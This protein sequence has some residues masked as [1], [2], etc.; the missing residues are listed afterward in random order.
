MWLDGDL[1]ELHDAPAATPAFSRGSLEL[2]Q[3]T[4][5]TVSAALTSSAATAD[6]VGDLSE[7][8][9]VAL[10]A[11]ERAL[12]ALQ[13]AEGELGKLD[14]AAGDGDH[15]A[16]MVRGMGAAVEAARGGGGSAGQVLAKAGMAFSGAA[17]GASGALYGAWISAIGQSLGDDEKPDASAVHR[18]LDSSLAALR[19]IGKAKP[20]DKTMIDTL[21]PFVRSFGEPPGGARRSTTPAAR[22]LPAAERGADS[23]AD[24]ISTRGRASKLGERSRGHKDPGAVSMLYVLRAAGDALPKK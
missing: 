6:A 7:S 1:Q 15:G 18:A 14:A 17:G 21:D 23:T 8:G 4:G 5:E 20:G 10:D 24:M 22:A 12:S 16:G 9:A 3:E 2:P 13:D 19:E 11:L